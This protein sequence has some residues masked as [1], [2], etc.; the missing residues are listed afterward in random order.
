[1]ANIVVTKKGDYGI[2]VD[3]GVYSQIV[4]SPQGFNLRSLLYITPSGSGVRVIYPKNQSFLITHDSNYV[5]NEFMIVDSI[6]GVAP[7]SQA[8]LIEKITAL[9]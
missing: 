5:G 9:L 4:P 6:N 1:M 7:T 3:F 8:D 2:F